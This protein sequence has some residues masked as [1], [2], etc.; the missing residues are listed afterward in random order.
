M[1]SNRSDLLFPGR[2][3]LIFRRWWVAVADGSLLSHQS[4]VLKKGNWHVSAAV[5]VKLWRHRVSAVGW[6]SVLGFPRWK[7]PN[8]RR[9]GFLLTSGF[10][11]VLHLPAHFPRD[12]PPHMSLNSSQVVLRHSRLL[13]HGFYQSPFEVVTLACLVNIGATSSGWGSQRAKSLSLLDPTADRALFEVFNNPT[14]SWTR[15][16]TRGM[17][18][19]RRWESERWSAGQPHPPGSD[20]LSTGKPGKL[21]K[22]SGVW[23]A[24]NTS[25][26]LLFS[27]LGDF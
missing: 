6:F 4:F 5:A 11:I 23:A 20:F 10:D 1:R 21:W 18:G 12:H 22:D 15:V 8:R 9:L 14:L 27:T 2:S 16:S 19:T 13:L 25:L 3:F 17:T 7:S 24:V 26:H